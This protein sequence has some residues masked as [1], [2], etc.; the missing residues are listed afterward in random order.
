[1]V[2]EGKE[3]SGALI[4]AG[5]ASYH[6]RYVFAVPGLAGKAGS[7][8]PHRA[9]RNGAIAVTNAKEILEHFSFLYPNRINMGNLK[10]GVPDEKWLEI[11]DLSVEEHHVRYKPSEDDAADVKIANIEEAPAVELKKEPVKKTEVPSVSQKDKKAPFNNFINQRKVEKSQRID[12]E[13]LGEN[14][15][16]VYYAMPCDTPLLPEEIHVE[17]MAV[18]DILASLTLLEMTG[19]VEAGA[20]GYFLRNGEEEV[21]FTL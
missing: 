16:K 2:V 12:F 14:E 11:A 3:K 13:L 7:E 8:G 10:K 4:T 17:G 6:G 5:C 20:G 9:I 1:M 18:S 21:Q 19:T 15:K